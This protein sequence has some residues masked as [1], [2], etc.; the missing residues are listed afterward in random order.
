MYSLITE[1]LIES[2]LNLGIEEILVSL[3]GSKCLCIFKN[4]W[5]LMMWMKKS[6]IRHHK[7]SVVY[8]LITISLKNKFILTS[9]EISFI[10]KRGLNDFQENLPK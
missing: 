7:A 2:C 6:K 9:G 3:C 4:E 1:E 10:L 5:I 8:P